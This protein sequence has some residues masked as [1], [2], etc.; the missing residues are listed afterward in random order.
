VEADVTP[1]GERPRTR[2]WL[3]VTVLS[4]FALIAAGWFVRQRVID[5]Y[6]VGSDHAVTLIANGCL[7]APVVWPVSGHSWDGDEPWLRSWPVIWNTQTS[8]VGNLHVD[9]RDT[10]T[11]TA[12]S[13]ERMTFHKHP[14][15]AFYSASCTI[16]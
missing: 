9:S 1:T 10:A 2:P 5:P 16:P 3:V 14:E 11:F 4:L 8:V 7:N 15:G 13:G 6:P 12:S